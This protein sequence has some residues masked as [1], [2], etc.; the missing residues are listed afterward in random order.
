MDLNGRTCLT[1]PVIKKAYPGT[2]VKRTILPGLN[3]QKYQI[4]TT[5]TYYWLKYIELHQHLLNMLYLDYFQSYHV[6]TCWA[7]H[8]KYKHVENTVIFTKNA[9]NVI[10]PV[11][12]GLN[13]VKTTYKRWGKS[14]KNV[15]LGVH[16]FLLLSLSKLKWLLFVIVIW[17]WAFDEL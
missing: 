10:S 8:A 11:F 6:D 3:W 12:I 4:L 2:S 7:Q 16:V 17:T 14:P 15:V 9:M 1:S 5:I 13:K